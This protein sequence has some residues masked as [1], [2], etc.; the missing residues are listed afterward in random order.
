M[1]DEGKISV[2]VPVYNVED[3]LDR[4]V[5]SIISQTYE[6][7]EVILV[8]DGSPDGSP[9]MCDSWA[10][11]DPRIK[12]IHKPNG[13]V[14]SAR[15]AALDAATGDF[16]GFVDSDD[17]IEN[18][19]YELLMKS[20]AENGSDI[21]F[22]GYCVVE[23]S[24]EK[25]GYKN[26]LDSSICD[27]NRYLYNVVSGGDGGFIWNKLFR[28]KLFD[29]VRFSD[30]IVY[31]E[32]LLFN[33]VISQKAGKISF[34]N[35]E[36]YNYFHKYLSGYAWVLNDHSFDMVKVFEEMFKYDMVP[37]V[38]DCCVRA[39][40]TAAFTLLSGVL[41]NEKYFYKYDEIRG[42]ILKFKKRILFEKQYPLKYKMKT[43]VLWLCPGLYNLMIRGI[44]KARDKKAD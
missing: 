27:R 26:L 29:G 34:V 30:E 22:C 25:K 8:D 15:N 2:V 41:T 36:K 18:D 38:Y 11:K 33:F 39:Y 1:V 20:L 44:R 9:V 28:A 37:K 35:E 19:F 6:N 40:M 10:Q 4:C 42:E 21:A 32:D 7:L 14:S 5:K 16:I 13:G 24:G 43:L 3:Y 17:W 31:S 23:R 12:V